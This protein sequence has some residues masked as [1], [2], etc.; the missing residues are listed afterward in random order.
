M[1]WQDYVFTGGSVLFCVT[2]VPMLRAAHKPPLHSSLP[3]A[4]TLFVFAATYATLGFVLAPA[5]ELVQ[6]LAW[7]ALAWQAGRK[8]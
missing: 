3:I 8:L 2:L 1:R 4:L 6:G 7:G 5:I